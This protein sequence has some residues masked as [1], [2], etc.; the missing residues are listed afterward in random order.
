MGVRGA[1][2]WVSEMELR[3][4]G[5]RVVAVP[6]REERSGRGKTLRE[7]PYILVMVIGS[8]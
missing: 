5:Y 3:E 2:A 4:E 7:P 1:L 8:S 6:V